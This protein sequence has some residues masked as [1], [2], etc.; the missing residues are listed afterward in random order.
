MGNEKYWYKLLTYYRRKNY[1]RNGLTLPYIIGSK[2]KLEPDTE[3]Q[4]IEEFFNEVQQSSQYLSI[5]R[6]P[7]IGEYVFDIS[8][9][10]DYSIYGGIENTIVDIDGLFKEK[11]TISE[12]SK[13]L[14]SK[15][16][17]LI[18]NSLFSR[19][20]LGYWETYDEIELKKLNEVK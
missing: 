12:F 13:K 14:E 18:S 17:E 5:L 10:N 2:T 3:L 7:Y 19:N 20:N 15:Y 11:I 8:E 16:S 4:K 1:F 9:Q 6:C